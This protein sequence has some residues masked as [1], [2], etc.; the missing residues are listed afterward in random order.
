MYGPALVQGFRVENKFIS[1]SLIHSGDAHTIIESLGQHAMV[2]IGYRYEN[3]QPRYLFQNWWKN[4][5]FVDVNVDYIEACGV[6]LHFVETPQTQMGKF[7]SNM[8]NHVEC[9]MLD[10]RENFAPERIPL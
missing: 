6:I 2:L 5:P 4:K 1:D 8:H 7:T 10:S 3:G 9:E